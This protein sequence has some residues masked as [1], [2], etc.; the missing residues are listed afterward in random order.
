MSEPELIILKSKGGYGVRAA[1]VNQKKRRPKRL[2]DVVCLFIL[3]K[4]TRLG[5]VV[6]FA[7]NV[8]DREAGGPVGEQ[9]SRPY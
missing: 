4:A 2:N 5:V 9:I 7:G 3:V 6:L 8:A 1:E